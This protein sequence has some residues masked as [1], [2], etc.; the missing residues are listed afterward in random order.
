MRVGF[1]WGSTGLDVHKNQDFAD[2]LNY[3]LMYEGLTDVGALPQVI[4]HP[5]LAKSWQVSRDGK[6][7]IFYLRPP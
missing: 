1:A 4:M 2:Y 7:Y 6:E 5:S 3:G